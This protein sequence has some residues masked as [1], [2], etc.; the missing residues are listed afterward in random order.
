MTG[1]QFSA[2]VRHMEQIRSWTPRQCA[3]NLGVGT[4]Q[5]ATWRTRGSPRYVD[6]A[7]SAL[8]FGLIPFKPRADL[9]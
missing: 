1:P 5:L 8:A 2:W 4:A 9:L 3:L 6:L 7:C